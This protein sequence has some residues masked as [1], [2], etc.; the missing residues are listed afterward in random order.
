VNSRVPADDF[1]RFVT[2]SPPESLDS[3]YCSTNSAYD[4]PSTKQIS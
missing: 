1:A 4:R 2:M 3:A